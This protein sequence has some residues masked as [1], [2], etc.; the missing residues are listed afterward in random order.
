MAEVSLNN[1]RN[2]GIMAHIDAGKTTTTERMLY[3]TGIV[4]KMGEV[5][6]GTATMDWM[7]QEQERGVTITSAATTCSWRDKQI[8]ILD[9]PGHV[10]FTVEVERSLRVLDGA[11][12]VFCAVGGVQPQSE[13][14]W[15]QSERY[16][17]P[18]IAF[19]NKMDRVGADFFKVINN[20]EEKIHANPIAV[21][22]PY[23]KDEEFSGI[24]DLIQMKLFT[25]EDELGEKMISGE[26][27]S[28]YLEKA[29]SFRENMLDN[30][31]EFDEKIMEKYLEG[32]K[33]LEG[34]INL[35]IRKATI[36]NAVHPVL[37]GT[38]LKNK[39]IQH[40]L[41]AIVNYLPAPVDVPP[42]QGH[43]PKNEKIEERK[44]DIKE[45][46][47]AL[48]FKIVT[49]PFVGRFTYV[50]VYSG[51]LKL[52][53][54]IYN[55]S[56][57]KNE[58]V[59]KIMRMHA[60][61]RTELDEIGPGEIVGLVGLK[62][63]FTGDTLCLKQRK[64]ILE[65]MEFP[66]P[67]IS[68]VVE[69]KT[70]ADFKKLDESLKKLEEEDPTFKIKHDEDTGQ[71]LIE[72][73]GEF[74]LEII[75]DRLL[76]EFKVQANVGN[77]HVT[78][79]ETF[80]ESYTHE[81]EYKRE[82]SGKNQYAKIKV[83]FEPVKRGQ[84][85]LFENKTS[86]AEIPK[87]YVEAVKQGI[88]EAAQNGPLAGYETVDFKATLVKATKD[89][90]NSTDVAFR[91]AGAQAFRDV[92]DKIKASLL[93]PVMKLEVT[94]PDDHT[95]DIINDLNIRRAKIEGMARENNFQIITAFVPLAKMFGYATDLRS[96]SQGRASYSMEFDHFQELPGKLQQELLNKMKGLIF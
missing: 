47:S 70:Q 33:L 66:E 74:H 44:A 11:I 21:Q 62:E 80:H 57:N 25:W 86:F 26:I 67:V 39:G 22:I 87:E 19:V 38:A 29:K 6:E 5:H 73:M 83:C 32:E 20:M 40:L 82:L 85:I 42:I 27:P 18:K 31:A 24:I 46:F 4:H 3:Y 9:T 49:D 76:R 51:K 37:C 77:P 68:V 10:D 45:P 81:L 12:A 17:V 41:D 96:A 30:I 15:R 58:R 69:P 53:M 13:T 55:A 71:L 48:A 35:L 89:D 14:V 8:N 34:E 52:G 50:R 16:N 43:N 94:T 1:I 90:L 75:V 60:A 63:T 92:S 72:G 78:Y 7:V 88:E 54:N 59:S 93:E 65:K 56:R 91:M 36:A 23:I 2:I 61:S 84:G 95:G 64:I 79:R 28:D